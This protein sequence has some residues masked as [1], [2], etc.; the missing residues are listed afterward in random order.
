MQ[1]HFPPIQTAH[2]CLYDRQMESSSIKHYNNSKWKSIVRDSTLTA[3]FDSTLEISKSIVRTQNFDSTQF[4]QTGRTIFRE[5]LLDFD[6]ILSPGVLM[7][8]AFEIGT[9]SEV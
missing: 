2:N 3:K 5:F 8:V 7:L 6:D 1:L 9:E 4:L